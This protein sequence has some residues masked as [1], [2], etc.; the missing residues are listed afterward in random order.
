MVEAI[1]VLLVG[2]VFG[3][4]LLN[5]YRNRR[6]LRAWWSQPDVMCPAFVSVRYDPPRP[7]A[8]GGEWPSYLPPSRHPVPR[9]ANGR[10]QLNLILR[11][12][13]WRWKDTYTIIVRRE[14][15]PDAD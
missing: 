9:N 11:T 10:R 1:T 3:M 4:L 13:N 15:P 12:D 5:S 6:W 7:E 8:E 2:F 14:S